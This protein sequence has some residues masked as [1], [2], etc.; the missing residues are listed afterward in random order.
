MMICGKC[1]VKF[2]GMFV[3]RDPI[4]SIKSPRTDRGFIL[5]EY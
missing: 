3:T 4:A 5:Y 2:K 1:G